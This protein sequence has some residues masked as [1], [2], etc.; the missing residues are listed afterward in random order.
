[1]ETLHEFLLTTKANEYLIAIAFMI[2]FILFWRVLNAPRPYPVREAVA[3][4]SRV[5]S[6]VFTHPSHTWAEVVQPN[7]VNVGM[8]E[9][10]SSVFGSIQKIELPNPGDRIFQGGNAWR[11]KRGQ[12]ELAQSAPVSGRVVEV[13]KELIKNPSFLNRQNP[14]KNWIL[15]IEPTNLLREVKNLFSGEML[16][17]WNQT[18]KEQLVATLVPTDYPVLQEGGEI[19]PDLG[20][21]LT[22]Q[23]W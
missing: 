5:I 21:E 14:E 11:I 7:L 8:D 23:Q 4:A 9:F 3:E 19:K 17:R 22:S 12:R 18:V 10:T 20:N 6:G 1:M 15:K 16:N 2:I 13:N